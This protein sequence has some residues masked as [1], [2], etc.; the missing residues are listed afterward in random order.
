ML[1]LCEG[2]HTIGFAQ[3]FTFK[4]RLFNFNGS[5]APDPQLDSSLASS[6]KSV[7]PNQDDSDT[8][9]V[10]LDS[11]TKAKFDNIYFKNVA[12]NSGILGSD[13]ALMNDNRTAAM[14]I[15]YSKYPYMFTKDFGASMAKLSTVG[16]I[17]DQNGEVRNK[18]NVVN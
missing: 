17:T 2:A 11:V 16:V 3:C 14:V 5:G 7:C 9:L 10:P 12:N 8:N 15:N 4:P 6:L 13:Q 18:C 1:F